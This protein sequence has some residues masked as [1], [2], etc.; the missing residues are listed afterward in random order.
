MCVQYLGGMGA[1]PDPRSPQGLELLHPQLL[2]LYNN[3][4]L[5]DGQPAHPPDACNTYLLKTM[6]VYA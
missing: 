5:V 6:H 3:F 2:S 4:K 1:A